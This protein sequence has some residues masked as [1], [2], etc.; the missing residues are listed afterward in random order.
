MF[1]RWRLADRI[2][3]NSI[4][5][6]TKESEISAIR[7]AGIMPAILLTL[8]ST[9]LTMNGRLSVLDIFK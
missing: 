6:Q 3:Y 9:R 4:V 8:N 7:E 2:I 5:P 1:R